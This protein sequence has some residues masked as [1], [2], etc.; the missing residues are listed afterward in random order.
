MKRIVA[1]LLFT[2]VLLCFSGCG[3]GTKAEQNNDGKLSVVVTSFVHYDFVRQIAG[4]N[5][6]IKML[7]SPA[8]EAHTYEPTPND[9]L[10]LSVCDMFVYTGAESDVWVDNVLS[11]IENKDMSIVSFSEIYHENFDV[12]HKE[13]DGHNHSIDE[14]F[15]TN[16]L[17][18]V[19]AAEYICDTLTEKDSKNKEEYKGN[20]ERF[21]KELEQISQDL[22]EIKQ[23]KVRNKVI[24]ADRFPFY[25]LSQFLGEEIE[26]LSPY[27]SCS[28]VSEPGAGAVAELSRIVKE[29]NIPCIFTIEFSNGKIA[30]SVSSS[31]DILTLHSCHT[32]SAKEFEEGITYCDL[33]R[34]NV[35]NLKKALCE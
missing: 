13:D 11:G 19:K 10:L 14:H 4:D 24:V 18:S 30:N 32:V 21:K 26:F 8:S 16:P 5:A 12:R 34:N 31:A 6:D 20:F 22:L 1:L 7:I 25:H 3:N 9:M 2:A 15:W 33:M 28:G 29:E 35:E 27:E 17:F 23:T